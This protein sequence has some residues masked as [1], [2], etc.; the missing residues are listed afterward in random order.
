MSKSL[1]YRAHIVFVNRIVFLLPSTI[2]AMDS[3]DDL[4]IVLSDSESSIHC[5]PKQISNSSSLPVDLDP[6]AQRSLEAY[7]TPHPS[8]PVH[9]QRQQSQNQSITAAKRAASHARRKERECKRAEKAAALEEQ[10]RQRVRDKI[11]SHASSGACR[12]SEL[13]LIVSRQLLEPS[14]RGKGDVLRDARALFPQ[15]IVASNER[16]G[17]LVSWRRSAPIAGSSRVKIAHTTDANVTLVLFS[18]AEYLDAFHDMQRMVCDVLAE[19]AGHKIIV[20]VWGV[21]KECRLRA[22]RQLRG[23][24]RDDIIG[25]QALQ[26]LYTRLFVE[27]GVGTQVCASLAEAATYIMHM[28]DAVAHVPYHRAASFLDASLAYRDAR[29]TVGRRTTVVAT[30]PA[31]GSQVE[32]GEEEETEEEDE[33]ENNLSREWESTSGG[34]NDQQSLNSPYVRM[35]GSGDLGHMYLAMLCMIPG[36]SIAKARA[37]RIRYATLWHLLCAYDKCP[38][39]EQRKTMLRDVRYGQ[40]GRRIGPSL[41]SLIANV[42]TG[43]NQFAAIK[44]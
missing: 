36:V 44:T 18:G 19:K 2:N 42:L 26:D 9:Q 33:V 37:I 7:S 5:L 24:G 17:N 11:E 25:L 20:V 14:C 40:S 21:V 41:S 39:D 43:T 30:R 4:V 23:A 38:S 3:D 28:T 8:P 29:R 22:S 15:Q 10:R 12:R 6:L 34:S 1:R 16:F 13:Q 31:P 32:G 35:E 27:Y